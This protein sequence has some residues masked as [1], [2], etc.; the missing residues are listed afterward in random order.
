MYYQCPPPPSTAVPNL[1]ITIPSLEKGSDSRWQST[2]NT[3]QT[4][5]FQGKPQTIWLINSLIKPMTFT[6]MKAISCWEREAMLAA[7]LVI[8]KQLVS[9]VSNAGLTVC[10]AAQKRGKEVRGGSTPP[11]RHTNEGLHASS[12]RHWSLPEMA[13]CNKSQSSGKWQVAI[14][15][16]DPDLHYGGC[17]PATAEAETG[18]HQQ[19]PSA[20][21][22]KMNL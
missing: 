1:S 18:R 8:H 21:E 14:N 7:C 20:T 9:L 22:S 16:S 5:P 11:C 4:L 15:L 19:S 3:T 13:T 6:S 12:P 2:H 17:T 10:G